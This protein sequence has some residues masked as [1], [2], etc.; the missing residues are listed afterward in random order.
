MLSKSVAKMFDR[1]ALLEEENEEDSHCSGSSPSAHSGYCYP[2]LPPIPV[3][4]PYRTLNSEVA[5]DFRKSF[6]SAAEGLKDSNRKT[7][8]EDS[9]CDVRK[10]SIVE[11]N[12][13]GAEEFSSGLFDCLSSPFSCCWAA[14]CPCVA[15]VSIP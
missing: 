15:E 1:D 8:F 11:L 3:N 9:G 13:S 6:D 12:Y 7:S 14:I 10:N 2:P 4:S 5:I